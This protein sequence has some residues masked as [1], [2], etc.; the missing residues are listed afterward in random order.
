MEGLLIGNRE[1]HYPRLKCRCLT[2]HKL[3]YFFRFLFQIPHSAFWRGPW[4]CFQHELIWFALPRQWRNYSR[5]VIQILLFSP[6][7]RKK[8]EKIMSQKKS[9][10][11]QIFRSTGKLT[12]KLYSSS[13]INLKIEKKTDRYLG[14][15]GL[16]FCSR[17]WVCVHSVFRLHGMAECGGYV[18][19]LSAPQTPGQSE[20]NPWEPYWDIP[21]LGW[22]CVGK[23]RG[24]LVLTN[25]P[26][27]LKEWNL[28]YANGRMRENYVSQ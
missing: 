7:S 4:P 25:C 20:R 21:Q 15:E 17:Y 24:W 19:G 18:C 3:S 12:P 23:C 13:Y 10:N 5:P 16:L 8:L 9:R 11:I 1:N 2:F 26:L 22:P 6:S 27:A 28:S 14:K